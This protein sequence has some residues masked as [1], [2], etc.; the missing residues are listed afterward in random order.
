MVKDAKFVKGMPVSKSTEH[1]PTAIISYEEALSIYHNNMKLGKKSFKVHAYIHFYLDDQK[2]DGP[3]GVW[4][5]PKNFIKILIH[6]DGCIVPDFSTYLD[7]PEAIR[8]YNYYRMFVIAYWLTSN[9]YNCI[10]NLRWN[11][12][13]F[14]Y[15]FKGIAKGST[16][17]IGTV[18]C[19]LRN[20]INRMLFEIGLYKAIQQIK[21]KTII[22]YGGAKLSILNSLKTRGINIIVFKSRMNKYYGGTKNE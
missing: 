15:C 22:I 4:N 19:Q 12:D 10:H 3:S 6:F 14:G 7:F 17:A 8:K 1:I 21:P 11:S 5:K 20:P 9:N 13:S 18:A 2:F 16:V